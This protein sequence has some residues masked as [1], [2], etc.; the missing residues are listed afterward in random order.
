MF[1]EIYVLYFNQRIHVKNRQTPTTEAF[2]TA[3]NIY[4]SETESEKR[5]NLEKIV[6]QE[7]II[8]TLTHELASL[9]V[10]KKNFVIR[11]FEGLLKDVQFTWRFFRN[12]LPHLY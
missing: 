7:Q 6:A 3:F 4:L 10:K 2:R 9:K 5:R 8:E 12:P 1:N 11:I